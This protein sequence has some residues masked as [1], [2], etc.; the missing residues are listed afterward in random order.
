MRSDGTFLFWQETESVIYRLAH[1][2]A[3]LPKI[4]LFVDGMEITQGIQNSSNSVVLIQNR[5]TY[6]RIFVKSAGDSVPGV[7]ARLYGSGTGVSG[8]VGPVNAI[9]PI[10]VRA[11]PDRLALDQS[12]LFRLPWNWTQAKDLRLMAQ[13]NPS[14]TRWSPTADNY[15]PLY[16]GEAEAR[17]EAAGFAHA[18]ASSAVQYLV[19][20]GRCVEKFLCINSRYV[21]GQLAHLAG[22]GFAH[23]LD[24]FE[25]LAVFF[26]RNIQACDTS[27]LYNHGLLTGNVAYKTYLGGVF[28]GSYVAHGKISFGV[29]RYSYRRAGK[30][31]G[32]LWQA[33]SGVIG[34]TSFNSTGS[35]AIGVPG[36]R[37]KKSTNYRDSHSYI[38]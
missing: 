38:I 8:S 18:H 24:R 25:Q 7:T 1:N 35:L 32:G 30:G 27:G 12:F 16:E 20:I 23:N 22:F 36:D 14:A 5:P 9:G 28:A 37:Q 31:Y 4:N 3:A 19:E 33:R 26:K 6:V 11:N 21:I 2:A 17:A 10:T 13:V 34:Y 29:G 15:S